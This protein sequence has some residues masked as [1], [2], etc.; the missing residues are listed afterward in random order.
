MDEKLITEVIGKRIRTRRKA[1][2]ITTA[3]LAERIGVSPATIRRYENNGVNPAR[4]MALNSLAKA[5]GTIPDA[6]TGECAFEE[7]KSTA[8]EPPE[9]KEGA[10]FMAQLIDI[11]AIYSYH[12]VK[13]IEEA[14]TIIEDMGVTISGEPSVYTK[15]EPE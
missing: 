6:L 4:K 7:Q 9:E 12:I 13:A 10:V 15:N 14:H 2:G 8:A 1:L 5:L 11:L 3:E